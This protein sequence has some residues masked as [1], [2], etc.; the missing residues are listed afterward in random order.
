MPFTFLTG[1]CCWED[2]GGKWYRQT[3]ASTYLVIELHPWEGEEGPD[4][5]SHTVGL[6]EVDL[7]DAE[8][9]TEAL[10][11]C[12]WALDPKAPGRVYCPYDGSDVGGSDLVKVE[13]MHGHGS[14]APLG[15]WSGGSWSDQGYGMEW[16]DPTKAIRKLLSKAGKKAASMDDPEVYEDEMGKP[17]NAI[18]S[19][20]REYQRGELMEP[21]FRGIKDGNQDCETMLKMYMTAGGQTLGGKPWK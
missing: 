11:S 7:S 15:E 5:A 10:Q 18:G 21:I 17:V 1:D 19:S 6:S 4:G 13:A 12:G 20:A 2:H 3:G 16:D 14:K 9:L 8:A